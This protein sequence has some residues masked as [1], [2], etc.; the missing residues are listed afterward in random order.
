MLNAEGWRILTIAK[1]FRRTDPCRRRAGSYTVSDV[2]GR[3]AVQSL[4]LLL[5]CAV[6]P[7]PVASLADQ[8]AQ[9]V[10]QRCAAVASFDVDAAV[11]A[12]TR[13]TAARMVDVPAAGLEG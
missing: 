12:P 13:I 11:G 1:L 9:P 6:A 3:P 5:V 4:L 7:T 2:P 10:D 8:A